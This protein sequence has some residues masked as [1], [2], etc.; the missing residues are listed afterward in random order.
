MDRE[1]QKLSDD[2]AEYKK[3][4]G[5]EIKENN[6]DIEINS[7]TL[8]EYMSDKFKGFDVET[9]NLIRKYYPDIDIFDIFPKYGISI[10]HY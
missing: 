4:I 9:A 7:T 10:K 8:S 3:N 5:K 6:L 2:L 1:F